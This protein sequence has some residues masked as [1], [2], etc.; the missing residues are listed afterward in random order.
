MNTPIQ[1]IYQETIFFGNMFLCFICIFLYFIFIF[2]YS[3]SFGKWKSHS[4]E[5]HL[6]PIHLF[7]WV[8]PSNKCFKIKYGFNK[9]SKLNKCWSQL[10]EEIWYISWIWT[11]QR[12]EHIFQIK[13]KLWYNSVY[14]FINRYILHINIY[15]YIYYAL[16]ISYIGKFEKLSYW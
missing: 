15:I 4:F 7:P 5:K 9:A 14:I 1:T 16:Y 13:T 8:L 2:L 11:P 10:F 6:F 12:P 3:L